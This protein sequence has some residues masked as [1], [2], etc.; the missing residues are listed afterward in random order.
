[1][2]SKIVNIK[3]ELKKLST[4]QTFSKIIS[5]FIAMSIA[6]MANFS[7]TLFKDKPNK[8]TNTIETKI[9]ELNSISDNL[10]ALK[11]FMEKQKEIIVN[12]EE[13]IIKLNKKNKELN[14]I[15]KSK[16]ATVDAIM[17]ESE[18]RAEKN[19]WKERLIGIILGIIA[20]LI[21][22]LVWAKF[23]RKDKQ[24]LTELAK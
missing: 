22:S 10:T 21:A 13:L 16:Q 19:V 24:K 11:D 14:P 12:Q 2:N 7:V 1:M 17:W 20:S 4:S 15:V 3:I 8:P 9:K 18:K 5:S 23:T 6:I